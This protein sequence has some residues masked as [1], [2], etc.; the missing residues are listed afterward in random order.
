VF[1]GQ[2]FYDKIPSLP[3]KSVV[4]TV[5]S[6]LSSKLPPTFLQDVFSDEPYFL[7]PLVNTCQGFAVEKPGSQQDIAGNAENKW[8]IHENTELLGA[9]VPK[10]GEKRRKFFATNENLQRFH[11]EPDLVYSFD[12]YQHFMDL[13]SMRFVVTS[14]LGF[15]ISKIIGKQPMQLSMAKNMAGEGYYWNFEVWHKTLVDS[16]AD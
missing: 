15:D 4:N 5:F 10:D 12:G 2:E 3:P 16:K 13:N 14:F 7:S 6:L 11:F 1:S 9:E 8:A